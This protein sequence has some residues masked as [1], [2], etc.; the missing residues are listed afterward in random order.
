[1]S[2]VFSIV[3]WNLFKVCIKTRLNCYIIL[4]KLEHWTYVCQKI[5][6]NAL[7]LF[8]IFWKI[9]LSFIGGVW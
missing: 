6:D 9:Q 1:M 8:L 7:T 5:G 2:F 4:F 3:V